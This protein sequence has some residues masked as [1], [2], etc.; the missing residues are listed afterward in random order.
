MKKK[1]II[2]LLVCIS[3]IT[4]ATVKDSTI[5]YN[6]PDSV[7]AV[8]FLVEIK[9]TDLND[10]KR[11][12]AGIRTNL[13]SVYLFEHKGRRGVS[14]QMH[15]F[16]RV[17]STGFGV[18]DIRLGGFYFNYKWQTGITYKLMVAMASDTSAKICLYS[19]YIFLPDE[20]KWKLIG[21]RKHPFDNDKMQKPA[22]FLTTTKKS[23]GNMIIGEVWCQRSNGSWKYMKEGNPAPPI[24]NYYG[25]ADSIIQQQTDIKIIT[26]SITSGKTYAINNVN[27][28]YYTIMKEGTGRQVSVDDTVTVFYKGYLF[29][30]GTV[31]DQ[32]KDKPAVFSA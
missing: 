5:V 28:V 27:D 24:I 29:S 32:T 11:F 30:N 13:G 8:Q 16:S 7:K 10:T 26:D 21:S 1:F 2:I 15:E 31:F 14:F 20:N 12:T 18:K 4:N 9:I 3:T 19:A 17:V 23:T 6:L 22:S 25:H